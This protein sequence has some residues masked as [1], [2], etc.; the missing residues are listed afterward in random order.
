MKV[1]SIFI[2]IKVNCFNKRF[3]RFNMRFNCFFNKPSS[4]TNACTIKDSAIVKNH[5]DVCTI[6]VKNRVDA[7]TSTDDHIVKKCVDAC[8]STD[9]YIVKKICRCMY[10]N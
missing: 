7:C 10:S 4:K 1:R 6:I 5:V 8:T 3:N 9:D 2:N